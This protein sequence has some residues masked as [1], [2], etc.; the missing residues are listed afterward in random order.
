M[1]LLLTFLAWYSFAVMNFVTIYY[2]DVLGVSATVSG[3]LVVPRQLA[4]II[5]SLTAGIILGKT[6]AYKKLGVGFFVIYGAGMLLMSLFTSGTAFVLIL[7]AEMC[8]GI[9][10][11]GQGVITNSYVQEILDPKDIGTGYAFYG[12][13]G[14]LASSSGAAIG[15]CIINQIPSQA[16][17]LKANFIS[18]FVV[19]LVGI[20][21]AAF[22][23]WELTKKSSA[24]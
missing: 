13:L 17:G 9:G 24:K 23:K 10:I 14:S 1:C 5:T 4:Q 15:G 3:T 2:Q 20:L 8:F 11:S 12:F 16:A 19:I 18:Y 6:G 7:L 21:I 22:G